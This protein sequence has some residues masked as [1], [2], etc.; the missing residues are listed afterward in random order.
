MANA[1][2][3]SQKTKSCSNAAALRS[4]CGVMAASSSRVPTSKRIP[5]VPTASKGGRCAS[6]DRRS[7]AMSTSNAKIDPLPD[8]IDESLDEATFLWQRWEAELSS[9][10]R[11]LDEIWDWT[12]DRLA[13]ALDGVRVAPDAKPESMLAGALAS[14][15]SLRQTVLASAP[16]TAPARNARQLL[17]SAVRDASGPQLAACIRGMEVANLDGSFAPV[18]K[19]LTS[20]GPEHSAALCRLKAFRRATL[21]TELQTAFESR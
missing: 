2:G 4:R 8:L 20:S 5:T 7:R 13:G 19:V 6:T 9:P 18:S 12:E 14:D 17:A 11:N 16:A 10:H 15:D 21:G 1:C 3:S